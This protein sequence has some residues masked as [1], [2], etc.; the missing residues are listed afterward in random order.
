MTKDRRIAL[1]R[2]LNDFMEEMIHEF[3]KET[4]AMMFTVL[5]DKRSL[6]LE[7]GSCVKD[8]KDESTVLTFLAAKTFSV[9]MAEHQ[10]G[11][12]AA[13]DVLVAESRVKPGKRDA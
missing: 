1:A 9:V 12:P 5:D 3:G 10:N 8:R 2:K 4:L 11:E 6:I 7:R 13:G